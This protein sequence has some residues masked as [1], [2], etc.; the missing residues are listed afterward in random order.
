MGVWLGAS[1]GVVEATIVM[2]S[3]MKIHALVVPKVRK[4]KAKEYLEK[5]YT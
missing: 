3:F 1:G 4:S 2:Y 5:I